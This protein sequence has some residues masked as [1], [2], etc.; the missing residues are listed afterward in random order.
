[1]TALFKTFASSCGDCMFLVLVNGKQQ[2]TMMVD[3]GAVTDEIRHFII[4]QCKSTIDLLVVTHIDDDHILGLNDMLQDPLLMKP[5]ANKNLSIKKILYNTY[6]RQMNRAVPETMTR[7]QWNSVNALLSELPISKSV[8]ADMQEHAI[9]TASSLGLANTILSKTALKKAWSV[10]T[11]TDQTPDLDLGVFGRIRFLSPAQKDMDNLNDEYNKYFVRFI[12]NEKTVKL[13]EKG[14]SVFEVL[15]R[16]ADKFSTEAD[17]ESKIAAENEI[18]SAYLEKMSKE[19]V[20]T[21]SI[22]KNNKASIAFVW[23]TQDE[24]HRILFMGDANPDQIEAAVIAKYKASATHPLLF[25]AIKVS[26]HGSHYNTTTKLMKV[27]DSPHY[28]F[29]GGE[30]KKRPHMAAIGRIVTRSIPKDLVAAKVSDRHLHFNFMTTEVQQLI[31]S[32]R[33][34]KELNFDCETQDNSLTIDC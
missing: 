28:F 12:T 25:D 14:E 21:S 26:H 7:K 8:T 4:N 11:V 27:I 34:Q 9:S 13:Y 29:T 10:D 24:K 20:V 1:M 32:V 3:C 15:L 23:E 22:T 2:W 33:T 6:R 19:K 30:E 16:Y 5:A 18:T 17:S 31:D